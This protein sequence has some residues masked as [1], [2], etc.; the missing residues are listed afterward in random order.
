[1]ARQYK[2][3]AQL[4]LPARGS[5]QA[6]D[7]IAQRAGA[8]R[9]AHLGQLGCRLD[10]RGYE[11]AAA[12]A[13]T[14]APARSPRTVAASVAGPGGQTA[15]LGGWGRAALRR[16][17]SGGAA[18]RGPRSGAS[19]GL[20]LGALG[21]AG[22][23]APPARPSPAPAP[24][25]QPSAPGRAARP[26]RPRRSALRCRRAACRCADAAA[27]AAARRGRYRAGW[28]VLAHR[29]RLS[30][31]SAAAIITYPSMAAG[32]FPPSIETSPNLPRIGSEN[33]AARAASGLP[34]A[35]DHLRPPQSWRE[36]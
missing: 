10:R 13:P 1:M 28:A 32:N 34:I 35:P 7:G 27:T 18:F 12:G 9:E 16:A 15:R 31:S 14:V 21:R 20:A 29:R 2:A 3:P 17:A 24:P 25:S 6:R 4:C 26:G 23:A 8:R 22:A 11:I 33:S 19:R 30:R 36:H 5:G